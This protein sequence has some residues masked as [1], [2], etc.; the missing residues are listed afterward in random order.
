MQFMK[1]ALSLAELGRGRVSPNPMVGAVIEYR[2]RIIGEGYHRSFGG[3][4]AEVEA[5]NSV[6]LEDRRYLSEASLYCTLEPCSQTY[7]GKK[8]PPCCDA[9]INSKLKRVVISHLDPNP[10]VAGSGVKRL[11]KSGIEVVVGAL[12]K[13]ARELNRGFLTSIVKKRP[14]IHLK[15]A[16]SLDGKIAT[17]SGISK[18]I[19]NENCRRDTHYYRSLYDGIMVGARTLL[20]DDP[21]L[22][23]RYGFSPSP[24]PVIFDRNL[25]I[26]RSL[27]AFS[28]DPIIITSKVSNHKSHIS[29]TGKNIELETLLEELPS[30]GITS[31]FVEGGSNLLTKFVNKG[32]WDQITIYIAPKL[33]G[34]GLS[35]L[36][37]IGIDHPRESDF[38]SRTELKTIDDH[39]VFN[40]WQ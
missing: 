4:H 25:N 10:M 31:L 2:G 40:G 20:E 38:F 13:E 26:N 21:A 36:G 33:L 12:E 17:A 9:I 37:N 24:R 30:R 6:S 19:S 27:K 32:V 8:R 3:N 22:D 28:R 35:P 29:F 39:F 18:W 23:A 15:W 16:Q 14:Y 5:L 1:R 7:R 11:K 34:D